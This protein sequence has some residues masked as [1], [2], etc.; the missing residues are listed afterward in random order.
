ML[1]ALRVLPPGGDDGQQTAPPAVLA[2][3][4]GLTGGGGLGH[5]LNA[6]AGAGAPAGGGGEWGAGGVGVGGSPLRGGGEPAAL[7]RGSRALLPLSDSVLLTA[8]ADASLRHW[9]AARP[10]NCYVARSRACTEAAGEFLRWENTRRYSC[11]Q[12][13]IRSALRRTMQRL[14]SRA[15]CTPQVAAPPPSPPLPDELLRGIGMGPAAARRGPRLPLQRRPQYGVLYCGGV[16]ARRSSRARLCECLPE[17]R[18]NRVHHAVRPCAFKG[19]GGSAAPSY[20]CSADQTDRRLFC[21]FFRLC[22]SSAR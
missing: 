17:A 18:R 22:T 3:R 21:R 20:A 19:E 9:D 14:I 6:S 12:G 10:E 1:R 16:Q 7:T 2:R 4:A 5:S 13:V 11:A 15:I 8:G